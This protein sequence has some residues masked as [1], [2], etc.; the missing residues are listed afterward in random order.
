ML[1]HSHTQLTSEIR[2]KI[3]CG[4]GETASRAVPMYEKTLWLSQMNYGYFFPNEPTAS[5]LS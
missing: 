5:R 3:K 1:V 2:L 4:K